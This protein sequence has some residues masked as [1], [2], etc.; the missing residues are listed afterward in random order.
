M[1]GINIFLV[2]VL[3]AVSSARVYAQAPVDEKKQLA[4]K[5]ADEISDMRSERAASLIQSD[6][7]VT[8]QL[9]KEVCGAVKKRAMKLAMENKLRIRHAAIKNRNPKH[10]ATDEERQ[11]H[12]LFDT[13]AKVEEVWDEIEIEGKAYSRY[14]RPIF[15]EPACLACHGEKDSRPQFIQKKYP[16]DRAFGFKTGDL[17]GI[18]EVMVPTE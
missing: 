6:K 7:A 17:R 1:K 13:D 18:I 16:G 4:K 15:V 8:P 10:A 3:I 2:T 9:F 14:I 11:F 5:I 12:R